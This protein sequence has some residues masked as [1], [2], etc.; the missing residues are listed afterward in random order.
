MDAHKQ[1]A[2]ASP[3]AAAIEKQTTEQAQL[4]RWSWPQRLVR[5]IV[6]RHDCCRGWGTQRDRTQKLIKHTI[7]LSNVVCVVP[8]RIGKCARGEWMKKRNFKL[9][10]PILNLLDNYTVRFQ[11]SA[12][13]NK[14]DLFYSCALLITICSFGVPPSHQTHTPSNNILS[15]HSRR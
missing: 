14:S 8:G 12:S 15:L 9:I 2:I 11:R 13:R 3:A 10:T 4:C 6:F 7:E 1:A 5:L